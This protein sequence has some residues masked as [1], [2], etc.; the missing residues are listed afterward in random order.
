MSKTQFEELKNR[1]L[2]LVANSSDQR[3]V[4]TIMEGIQSLEKKVQLK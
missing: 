3:L 4:E 2:M 1:L